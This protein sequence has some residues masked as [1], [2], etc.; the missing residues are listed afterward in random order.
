MFVEGC[1]KADEPVVESHILTAVVVTDE[2]CGRSYGRPGLPAAV[3][4]DKTT[5]R[6]RLSKGSVAE[7]HAFGKNYNSVASRVKR[8]APCNVGAD[9][10]LIAQSRGLRIPPSVKPHT[11]A[12]D[13]S[14]H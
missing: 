5:R 1:P 9:H 6:A 12:K 14:K 8:W 13:T 10:C 2:W 11:L 7:A 4:R 3:A